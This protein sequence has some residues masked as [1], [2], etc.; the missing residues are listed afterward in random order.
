[1]ATN[2]AIEKENADD[3]P[4][5]SVVVASCRTTSL[6]EACLASLRPQ[7]K[8]CQA[9]LIVARNV[10]EAELELLRQNYPEVRFLAVPE[11]RG[12]PLLR[13]AGLKAARGSVVAFTE[14]H[15]VAATDWLQQL[16]R[17]SRE[18]FDV[19]GGAMD[20]AQQGRAVDWAAYFSE[21]GFFAQKGGTHPQGPLLTGANVAYARNVLEEVVSYAAQGEWEN[22]IHAHL[23]AAGRKLRF[24]PDAVI[25]QNKNCGFLEFCRDRYQ[26]GYDYARRRLVDKGTRRWLYMPGSLA[27][28][29]LQTARVARAVGRHQRW[30][31]LRA[32]PLTVAL[33]GAWS[34]GEAIGYWH[35]PAHMGKTNA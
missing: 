22:V 30:A 6:L 18:G 12:I 9:E 31:F 20:N 16:L 2:P 23:A 19:V 5:T 28:P 10:A 35:G 3:A 26:H 32:L 15:C 14:D 21:Y 25:Y 11:S 17:A 27:L 29:L 8:M 33:F 24:F 7:C 1:M 13:A 34:M 4:R